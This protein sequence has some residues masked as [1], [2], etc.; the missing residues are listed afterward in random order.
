MVTVPLYPTFPCLATS[1]SWQNLTPFS[2]KVVVPLS[3]HMTLKK[4]EKY[5]RF[6]NCSGDLNTR[7]PNTGLLLSGTQMLPMDL[8]TSIQTI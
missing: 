5:I 6:N 2:G 8:T 1:R 3:G 7:H 4:R